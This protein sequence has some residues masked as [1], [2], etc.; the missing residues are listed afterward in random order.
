[1]VNATG[2]GCGRLRTWTGSGYWEVSRTRGNAC[3][4]VLLFSP[5]AIVRVRQRLASMR[6][7][8]EFGRNQYLYRFRMPDVSA[9]NPQR[10]YVLGARGREFVSREL[11]LS[12]DKGFRPDEGRHLSVTQ[13][14][15]NLGLTRFLVAA[16]RWAKNKEDFALPA[17]RICYDLAAGASEV[18]SGAMGKGE[19]ATVIPDGWLLFE[20]ARG[21]H[22]RTAFRC[23]SRATGGRCIKSGLKSMWARASSL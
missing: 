17:V 23:L 6:G 3:S 15:H 1:M 18:D 9:G 7:G 8:V 22:L 11:G 14:R 4:S 13:V 19:K 20:K 16:H 5:S 10:V 12:S 21:E 2:V